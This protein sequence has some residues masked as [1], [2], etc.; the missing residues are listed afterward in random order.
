MSDKDNPYQFKA[1]NIESSIVRS[2]AE[3]PER[4]ECTEVDIGHMSAKHV[5]GLKV[6]RPHLEIKII[7]ESEKGNKEIWWWRLSF[8]RIHWAFR[9]WQD[10]MYRNEIANNVD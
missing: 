3:H 4:W 5:S 1:R 10:Q 2:F 7:I 9:R 6:Y 8:W